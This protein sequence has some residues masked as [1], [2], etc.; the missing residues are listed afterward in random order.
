M[1]ILKE[2]TRIMKEVIL[3]LKVTV[4]LKEENMVFLV[5]KI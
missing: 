5:R 2:V 4:I 1:L 3:I